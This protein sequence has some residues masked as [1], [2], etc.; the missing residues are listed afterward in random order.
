MDLE[1]VDD[2]EHMLQVLDVLRELGV[3]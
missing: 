2:P 3:K 1:F